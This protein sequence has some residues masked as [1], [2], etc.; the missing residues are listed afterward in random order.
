MNVV[1]RIR[2]EISG[3]LEAM[4]RAGEL[5]EMEKSVW[6]APF[7]SSNVPAA[8]IT[9]ILRRTWPWR[10]RNVP[11][12][13]PRTIAEAL[14]RGLVGSPLVSSAT[15]AGPGF[16]NLRVHPGAFMIKSRRSWRRQRA[17]AVPPRQA[18]SASTSSS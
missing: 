13:S 3:V 2:L 11:V 5:G 6:L 14:V 9:V 10:S 12:S 17:T 8:R 7:G 4:A 16:V 15:V 18:E 1:D